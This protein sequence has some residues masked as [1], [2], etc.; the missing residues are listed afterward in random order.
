MKKA[1]FL[2]AA[3]VLAS[4]VLG[5]STMATASHAD[6][7][8]GGS[9]T[10]N[11]CK[12]ADF[13]NAGWVFEG[14][15]AKIKASLK[16]ESTCEGDVT[17]VSYLAPR[18][19]FAVPQYLFD[20]ETYH[21]DKDHSSHEF[22]VDLPDCNTQVDLFVGGKGA[23]I[24]E[25]KEGGLRYGDLKINWKNFGT[26]NCVQPA[27]QHSEA[28][29]GA[30]TV[31]LSNNGKLSGY[32]VDFTVKYGN[33]TKKVTVGKGKSEDV[34]I[35]AGSGPIT[36][37]ADKLK[38][39]TIEWTLPESCKPTATA[40]NDCKT[41]VVTVNNPSA[42]DATT[43]VTY[44]GET[45]PVTVPA[46]KSVDVEFKSAE[47]TAEA[48]VEFSDR[49]QTITVQVVLGECAN[50]EPTKTVSTSPSASASSSP[51]ASPSAG[52]STSASQTPAAATP[53]P[54]E[55]DG[56]ELALTGAAG[57]SI[58]GGAGVLLVLGAGLFFMA[59]RRKVNFKA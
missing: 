8:T 47:A 51:S 7:N 22:V 3:V 43:S 59:R 45:K 18:P 31:N 55:T 58:A 39:T 36:V 20:D 27:V 57:G 42:K 13:D 4:A 2:R 11:T 40:T 21:F 25:L 15:Y 54:S 5:A 52:T 16:S 34:V 14:G 53:T 41:T 12:T 1:L 46:G 17:L 37:S 23:I 19:D 32:A 28:C 56:G 30:V 38:E 49:F 33:E 6:D 44:N 50:P 35:P 26:S 10:L 29:D 24:P 9:G 48:K